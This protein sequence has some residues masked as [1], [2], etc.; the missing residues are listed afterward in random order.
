MINRG[1][2]RDYL[3][4]S[5][6]RLAAID[7]LYERRAWADVV[8]ESQE[9][10]ELSMKALLRHVNIDAPRIHDVGR[11]VQDHRNHLPE[12]L[13]PHADRMAAISKNLRRDREIAFYGSEDLTPSDFYVE[14]DAAQARADATWLV[15][16]I[17]AVVLK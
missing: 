8:R 7:V 10:V 15:R 1:L 12:T 3:E 13:R 2:V 16:T 6:H 11:V 9:V 5:G 4:R 17:E 14:E